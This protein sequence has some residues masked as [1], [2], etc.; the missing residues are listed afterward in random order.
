MFCSLPASAAETCRWSGC[1]PCEAPNCRDS[2]LFSSTS[3]APWRAARLAR[4]AG[5]WPFWRGALRGAERVRDLVDV[6]VAD[7]LGAD[8]GCRAGVRGARRHHERCGEGQDGSLDGARTAHDV[9]SPWAGQLWAGAGTPCRGVPSGARSMTVSITSRAQVSSA[10]SRIGWPPTTAV[11]RTGHQHRTH[12]RLEQ[13]FRVERLS[14]TVPESGS[15][16][17]ANRTYLPCIVTSVSPAW[18]A[19]PR[20]RATASR[21][22]PASGGSP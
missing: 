17:G 20:N 6:G 9:F 16:T 11:E 4:A 7:A 1:T 3:R 14:R 8:H 22:A 2:E 5:A 19:R 13:A 10:S 12:P 15:S 21:L 18:R